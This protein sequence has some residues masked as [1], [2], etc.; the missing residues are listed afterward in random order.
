MSG[1]RQ[2]R[3]RIC[4]RCSEREEVIQRV[5]QLI[6]F[7]QWLQAKNVFNGGKCRCVVIHGMIDGVPGNERRYD[8]SGD[9]HTQLL[10]IEREEVVFWISRLISRSNSLWWMHVV[11]KSPV[12]II[13]D[14]QHAT[15][16]VG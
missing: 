7:S 11:I 10:K 14:D 16:P 4:S 13:G 1:C 3:G 12:F 15:F 2:G 5:C 8:Y 9:A 6:T